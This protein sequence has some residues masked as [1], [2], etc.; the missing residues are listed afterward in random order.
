MSNKRIYSCKLVTRNRILEELR[1]IRPYKNA[2]YS[3]HDEISLARLFADVFQKVAR[4][5]P[6]AREWYVFTGAKWEKDDGSMLTEHLA[7]VFQE[8]LYSYSAEIQDDE[9]P[10]S[11][12]MYRKTVNDLSRRNRRTT[13]IQDAR[14]FYSIRPGELDQQA[15]GINLR[16]G[17]LP[18]DTFTL[19]AHDPEMLLTKVAGVSYDPEASS[20]LIK[21]TI[22]EIMEG[23]QAKIDY[24][25]MLFGYSLTAD[26][27]QEQ[28]YLFH[29]STSRN[30][31]S[32]LLDTFGE[33]MGDYAATIA[34][35]SLARRE[36]NARNASGD[37][38]RLEGVRFLHM[39]EPPKN[40]LFDVALLKTLLGRDKI[41]ARA[42]YEAERE[43][44]PE[45]KLFINTNHLPHVSDDTIFASE[46]LKVVTFDRHFE[47]EEQD[48]KLKQRLKQPANL[49]GFLNWCLDG[50]RKYQ[51]AGEIIREPFEVET[52]TNNYRLASDK[53]G[54]F[55]ED[56][57]MPCI[58]VNV[59]VKDAYIA[60]SVWCRDNG[61]GTESKGNFIS[62]MKLRNLYAAAGT[63]NGKTVKNVIKDYLLTE[64][65]ADI[66]PY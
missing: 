46:R 66:S 21:K 38:A 33:L 10:E 29:G 16:N 19:Q 56:C 54:A 59:S 23:N 45:F 65:L 47:P 52:A 58:G 64:D 32:T 6:I 4:Y 12:R 20:E 62:E 14:D 34:P 28:A 57:L 26:T 50:L 11:L 9:S 55:I 49:S 25:Q 39:A 51:A 31:K 37:I 17:F 40:M 15:H 41:V 1:I 63:V 60:F 36:R 42:M 53:F 8:A 35:E 43:F 13:M 3:K 7:K 61:Y 44:F 5:N 22:S 30:G 18:F 27:S 48:R 2:L 24:I